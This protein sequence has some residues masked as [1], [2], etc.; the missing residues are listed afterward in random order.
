MSLFKSRDIWSYQCGEDETFDNSSVV[1]ADI[2]NRGEDCIVVGSHA[3][4]IRIF[5]PQSDAESDS[6]D[7]KAI[8][9]FI[10]IQLEN[11]ILQ[12]AVG[13]LVS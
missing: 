9:L 2:R 3:G 7:Y 11:P 5:Q 4:Y 6:L 13:K 8:D 12:V 1:V 10:E